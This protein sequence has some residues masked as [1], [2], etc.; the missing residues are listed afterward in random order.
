MQASSSRWRNPPLPRF[1]Q[2]P[3]AGGPAEPGASL[4]LGRVCTDLALIMVILGCMKFFFLTGSNLFFSNPLPVSPGL[5]LEVFHSN[6]TLLPI[7][8]NTE[9]L[10]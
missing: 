8:S 10:F 9:G 2:T 4:T 6:I 5:H 1:T 7:A 3:D